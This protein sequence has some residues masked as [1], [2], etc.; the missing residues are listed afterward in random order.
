M[1]HIGCTFGEYLRE[2]KLS[3]ARNFAGKP[4]IFLL[5]RTMQAIVRSY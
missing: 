4:I 1:F 3:I 5:Q 2:K